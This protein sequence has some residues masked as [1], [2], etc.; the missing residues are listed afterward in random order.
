MT[1]VK[2]RI[3]AFQRI[4]C[5][6][7]PMSIEPV[8]IPRA[9]HPISRSLVSP[10]AL[11]V[12][13][14]LRDN[15]YIAYLVG[16]CVRDLLLGRE[17]KDFDVATDATPNQIKRIFRNCRLVGR[18]FRLAHIHF[19]DEIIEVATFRALS[20]PEEG[21]GEPV[22]EETAQRVGDEA[23]RLRPPRH[24][25][26][27]EGMVLRDNVFGTP[28]EDA[29]R[30]DFTVNALAYSIADF[31]IIDYAGGM[32]DLQRGMIR[33]IGDPRARF[34]E[35]P[36]RMLRAVRFAAV[37]GFAVEE[38]TWQAML[39]LAPA[40]TRATAPRLYE[41]MLKLFLSGEGERAYQLLRQTGLFAHLFPGFETWLGEETDG[42]P[43]ARTGSALEWVDSQVGSGEP[44]SPP[45][46]LAL[47]FGGY[48]EERSE[49]FMSQGVPP[50][51]AVSAAVA[52]FLGEQAPLVAV[53]HRIGLAVREILALQ[54]RLRRIPGK[55]PQS[56]LA[57][58]SFAE[59]MAYLRCRSAM[60]GEDST[61]LAWWE[62]YAR[63]SVMPPV[64]PCSA[65]GE[66]KKPRRRRR[67]RGARKAAPQ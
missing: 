37:L 19:T 10:N 35:D 22:A 67:R 7:S 39:D 2:R 63:E 44:V 20:P 61:V 6:E 11:R 12:L 43:H 50:L 64:E 41:E 47:L 16:G 55:R 1:Q 56:V 23:E 59:S 24:L 30:R 57:R 48:L 33:T 36:V 38:E 62:R 46:L 28:G 26:S 8:I 58:A 25:V 51:D 17:P 66:T 53:P 27:D 3:F 14:R 29:L 9:N 34:T 40:I 42:F 13:Y 54:H 65:G 5:Y 21:E 18:R 60:N 15:G 32:E 49:L 52:A 31:S 4:L 45:L